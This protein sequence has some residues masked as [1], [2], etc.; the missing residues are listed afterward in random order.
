[1]AVFVDRARLPLGRMLMSHMIADSV[2]ELHEMAD[3]IGLKREWF[4][5]HGFPHYDIC[6]GKRW[7]AIRHGAVPVTTRM[8]VRQIQRIRDR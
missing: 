5:D 8:M 6:Q 4:Q 7:L 1:M 2:E 3:R